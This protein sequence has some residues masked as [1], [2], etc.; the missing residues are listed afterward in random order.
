MNLHASSEALV[1]K[2]NIEHIF[3]ISMFD[4]KQFLILNLKNNAEKQELKS[5]CNLQIRK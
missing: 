2:K 5:T 1:I 3:S 4:S